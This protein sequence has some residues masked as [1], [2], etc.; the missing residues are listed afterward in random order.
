MILK[1][2]KVCGQ[3]TGCYRGTFLRADIYEDFL[4][5]FWQKITTAVSYVQMSDFLS[6][7]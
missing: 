5:V 4:F 6:K 2:I 7:K 1:L 3:A